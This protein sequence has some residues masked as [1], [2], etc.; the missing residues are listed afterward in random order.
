MRMI[1][2]KWPWL[3]PATDR[4][5]TEAVAGASSVFSLAS[6]RHHSLSCAEFSVSD[7]W[8]RLRH[9]R[10]WR[11]PQGYRERG[12][13]REIIAVELVFHPSLCLREDCMS[14]EA[15][16]SSWQVG[17]G[18]RE[19]SSEVGDKWER[20]DKE[21]KG[22]GGGGSGTDRWLS[23]MSLEQRR[24]RWECG[25]FVNHVFKYFLLQ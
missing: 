24:Q 6:E 19:G 23:E 22:G 15:L 10:P 21:E 13:K 4:H 1:Y 12:R 11:L 8:T 17:R 14:Q 7:R 2:L 3:W 16:S 9:Q 18:E 25:E 20:L 5:K